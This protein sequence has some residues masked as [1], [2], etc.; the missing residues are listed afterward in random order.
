MRNVKYFC[1][2]VVSDQSNIS[3]V[4]ITSVIEERHMRNCATFS[5]RMLSTFEEICDRAYI[6]F[7]RYIGRWRKNW[8]GNIMFQM[9]KIYLWNHSRDFQLRKWDIKTRSTA[10]AVERPSPVSLYALP[11]RELAK[12][13]NFNLTFL[14][15]QQIF[16]LATWSIYREGQKESTFKIWLECVT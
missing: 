6:K 8:R 11:S 16:P 3:K 9:L 4:L 7:L 2:R 15:I 12:T 14:K 1:W 13:H 5:Q 10:D